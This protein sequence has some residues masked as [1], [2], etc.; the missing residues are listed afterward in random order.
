VFYVP[1][2]QRNP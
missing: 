2:I 1:M